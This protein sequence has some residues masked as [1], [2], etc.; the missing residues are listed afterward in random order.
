MDNPHRWTAARTDL[1][2]LIPVLA[3][4]FLP[5]TCSA[6]L[7]IPSGYAPLVRRVGPSVVTVIV[8]EQRIGAGVRAAER[9]NAA[10]GYDAVGALIRR[11]LSGAGANPGNDGATGALGSGFVIRA[12]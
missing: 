11:L 8:E 1:H 2:R 4:L 5:L 10:T 6:A 3:A 7:G 9:V 12:D